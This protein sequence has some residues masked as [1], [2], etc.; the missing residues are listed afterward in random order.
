VAGIH[1]AR[2]ILLSGAEISKKDVARAQWATNGPGGVPSEMP[3]LGVYHYREIIN[4]CSN[5]N[6]PNG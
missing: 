1:D 4:L 5:I 6:E 2:K 3:L